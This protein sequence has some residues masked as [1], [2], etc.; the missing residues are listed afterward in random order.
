MPATPVTTV[1]TCHA[2][3]DFD[4]LAAMI[5]AGKL[6]PGAVLV[7]PGTQEASL[8]DYFIQ[9]A[10]YL[11]NFKALKDI[12]PSLVRLLVVV[13]TRQ[14]SRLTHVEPL[15]DLPGLQIHIYDHHPASDDALTATLEDYRPWGATTSI[16]VDRLQSENLIVTPDEGSPSI[17]PRSTIFR[18]QRGSGPWAWIWT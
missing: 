9:S 11:F 10:M 8:K 3:A 18:P 5:A 12:D 6:Y 2:N 15:F 13:D 4:A 7:F 14:R 1:I 17:R 16:I